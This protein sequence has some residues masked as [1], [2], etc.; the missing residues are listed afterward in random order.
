LNKY[1]ASPL[2]SLEYIT[3]F[4]GR[5]V[6]KILR[7]VDSREIARVLKSEDIEVREKIFKNMSKRAVTM[8]K[9]DMEYMIPFKP[10]TRSAF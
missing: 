6:Q 5:V 2:E 4:D 1:V 7:E 10:K 3:I 8:L 9:E